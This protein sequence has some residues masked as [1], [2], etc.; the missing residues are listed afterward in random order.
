MRIGLWNID[1]PEVKS[2]QNQRFEQIKAFLLAQKCHL[3][4]LTEANSAL[5][6]DGYHTYFSAES[7]FHK[8]GRSY[9]PPNRYHQVA[10]YSIFPLAQKEIGEPV[11]GVLCQTIWMERPLWIYGNV[12]TIKDQ[13]LKSSTK[14]YSDRV[15]EQL[16]AIDQLANKRCLI[17]GDF[18]LKLGWTAKKGAYKR[19]Q[20]CVERNQL[21]WPTADQTDTVQHVLHSPKL[22]VSVNVDHDA[23]HL[24]DHPFISMSLTE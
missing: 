7:P 12:I 11:N 24:S 5:H 22:T 16:N 17:A 13:W 18:N 6:L 10:I 4:I 1:H 9:T 21:L 23:K 2:R 14:K 8:K 20:S 19:V 3:Y 15:T